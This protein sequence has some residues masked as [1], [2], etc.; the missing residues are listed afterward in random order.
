MNQMG[1]RIK[2]VREFADLTQLGFAKRLGIN[3]GH[4]SN[5]ETGKAIPSDQLIKLIC[6]LFK[7]NED[8]L[9]HGIDPMVKPETD[10]DD[11]IQ[12]V[13]SDN[14]IDVAKMLAQFY[15]AF[16][17]SLDE[18]IQRVKKT[19]VRISPEHPRYAEFNTARQEII[20]NSDQVKSLLD[21]IQSV[22]QQISAQTS[23]PGIIALAVYADAQD[24]YIVAQNLYKPYQA[25]IKALHPDMDRQIL[26][27][28]AQANKILDEWKQNRIVP[29]SDKE[30]LRDCL[31][32][33]VSQIA[34]V[35]QNQTE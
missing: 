3:R 10:P 22:S 29:D 27:W 18:Q 11:R 9:R 21:S 28:F 19:G 30:R 33:I 34:Q 5:I 32:Q 2:S 20:S 25:T 14:I 15:S 6:S 23:D 4:V 7:I 13:A 12:E 1:N 8:W 35:I 26:G 16:L 31:W 17:S 24:A